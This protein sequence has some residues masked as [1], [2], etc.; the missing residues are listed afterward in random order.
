MATVQTR[1]AAVYWGSA[2]TPPAVAETRNISIDLGTDFAD[3]TVHGDIFRSESPTFNRFA[4]TVTGLYDDAAFTVMDD[5]ISKVQ[6]YFYI[7]PDSTD[8]TIYFYGRG[9][10]AVDENALPYDDFATLNWSVRPSG[11]VTYQHA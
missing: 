1:D 11:T 2:S 4:V 3:D 8:N 7:Y 9:Y 6:G 5:A 10:V